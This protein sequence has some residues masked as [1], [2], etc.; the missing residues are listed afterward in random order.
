MDRLYVSV[1]TSKTN[2]PVPQFKSTRPAC[3]LYNPEREALQ[4]AEQTSPADIFLLLGAGAGYHLKEL[5]ARFPDARFL[6]MEASEADIN[7]LK[8]TMPEIKRLSVMPNITIFPEDELEKM[9]LQ[10]YLPA[11]YPSFSVLELRSWCSE[12]LEHT[13]EIRQKIKAVLEKISCDFATQSHFGKIWQHNILKNIPAVK[14]IKNLPLP[15]NKTAVIAAAG[16]SLDETADYI[17]RNRKNVYVIS[18]DTA[19]QPLR[20]RG[21]FCDAVVSIDGQAVSQNHFAG[22]IDAESLF[23]FDIAANSQAV[24]KT[25]ENGNQIIFSTS[26]HPL[27][28][29]IQHINGKKSFFPLTSG[30]GTV[31][32]A[33]VDFASKAGFSEITVLGADFGYTGGKSYAKGT[34]LDILFKAGE[35]KLRTFETTFSALQ[36]RSPLTRISA[37]KTTTKLLESYRISFE[38]WADQNGFTLENDS[39]IYILHKRE[40]DKAVAMPLNQSSIDIV[41]LKSVAKEFPAYKDFR[42]EEY[43]RS[44]PFQTAFLPF[45]AYLRKKEPYSSRPYKA[46]QNLALDDFVL[47]TK[48]L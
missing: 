12:R 46:L 2:L 26:G 32:M 10:N 11:L 47:Y 43:D 24:R 20:R 45:I 25:A 8:Q 16:P 41:R 33:A 28:E 27:A 15:V 14:D 19:Y 39:E 42:T 18:T 44:S 5:S 48:L 7:F 38:E 1:L 36:Y 21:I 30:A 23:I 34:Y 17:C 13:V 31:T 35:N 4:F 9:L 37:K 3:S 29:L 6:V 22:T 40:K